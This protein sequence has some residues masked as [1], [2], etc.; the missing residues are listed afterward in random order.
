M[1]TIPTNLGRFPSLLGSQLMLRN[2]QSTQTNLLRTQV[3]L[4]TGR[5]LLRPSDDALTAQSIFSLDSIISQ[6]MRHL[7][8]LQ[9]A[10]STLSVVD[11][12]IGELSDLLLEAKGLASS[13]LGSGQEE[14]SAEADAAAIDA[15]LEQIVSL[16]N[17][18]HNELHLFGGAATGRSP[19]I[20]FAGGYR[21]R[22]IGSG[23]LTD[24]GLL[25]SLPL[26][27]SGAD[28]F[29]SLS[30]RVEG[31]HDL[32]PL[33]SGSTRLEDLN[34]ARGFGVDL[35]MLRITTTPPG[36]DVQVDLSGAQDMDDV[37][38]ALE[39]AVPGVFSLGSQGLVINPAAGT[40]VEVNELADGSTAADLGL[41]GNWADTGPHAGAD[42]DPRLTE[43]TAIT[44]LGM[45][46]GTIRLENV[47]Q[48]HDLDLSSAQTI[49]D[50][51]E[52]IEDLD[53]GI[54]VEISESGDRLHMHNEVSGSRM[55]IGEVGGGSTATDLGIRSMLRSTSLSD[56]NDG[57]GV[58]ILEGLSDLK[59]TLHDDS[60]FEVDLQGCTNV[61]DVIDAIDSAALLALGDP[62]PLSVRLASTG[63]GIELVD[64]TS[65]SGRLVVESM[66]GSLAPDQ[67]GMLG[68]VDAATLTGEDRSRV[69]V[70]SVFTH[71]MDLRSAMLGGDEGAVG[72]IMEKLEG[73]IERAAGA[74]A[75]AGHRSRMVL[76]AINRFESR[77]IM[78]ETLRTQLRDVDYTDASM[79][80]ATLQQQLQASLATTAR[81]SSLSLLEFLG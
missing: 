73:D 55:S 69:A 23:M 74:R 64:G 59:I 52:M 5:M 25:H 32:N 67:L 72:R 48:V 20:D 68:S 28:V 56:F 66:N 43:R 29:G 41:L 35:G 14:S 11:A 71:L 53:I 46:L 17:R 37:L 54:R 49:G 27:M 4:A 30:N 60:S 3:Q 26:T 80:F 61:G 34:G 22:G 63:N 58:D 6:R 78:D 79:R 57:A 75:Q 12:T 51:M 33:L 16:A 76:D 42:L 8:N 13:Y 70:E 1:L 65:G 40:T 38:A 24:L 19:L 39:A 21:Y 50:V 36:T 62:P 77:N 47:G 15:L 44:D 7:G 81:L 18:S 45:T 9:F 2:L 10:D 31:D